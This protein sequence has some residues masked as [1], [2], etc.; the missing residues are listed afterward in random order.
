MI[1]RDCPVDAEC[2]GPVADSSESARGHHRV[3]SLGRVKVADQVIDDM[4]P[5]GR[6]QLGSR[7]TPSPT[8]RRTSMRHSAGSQARAYQTVA[9]IP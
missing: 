9:E 1:L 6:V 3:G 8:Q 4:G 2:P 5:L 7:T